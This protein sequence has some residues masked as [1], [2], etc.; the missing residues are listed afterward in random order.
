QLTINDP[1]VVRGLAEP[2][3][4]GRR[5]SSAAACR[6][7]GAGARSLSNLAGIAN[8]GAFGHLHEPAIC[9][10]R[11]GSMQLRIAEVSQ[12]STPPGPSPWH[13]HSPSAFVLDP[14]DTAVAFDGRLCDRTGSFK[15]AFRDCWAPGRMRDG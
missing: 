14:F 13:A 6:W 3:G 4:A 12:M 7:A 8:A 9:A 1:Q 15:L 2:P 11:R 10:S 5:H